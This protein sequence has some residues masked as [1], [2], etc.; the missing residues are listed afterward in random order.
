MRKISTVKRRM[1]LLCLVPTVLFCFPQPTYA[2]A[3]T[4]Y[5]PGQATAPLFLATEN[6]SVG[7]S[8]LEL[9]YDLTAQYPE[10]GSVI[11][12]YHLT[13]FSDEPQKVQF[14]LPYAGI[15]Q[16]VY[17]DVHIELNG[18]AIP[19]RVSFETGGYPKVS[20]ELDEDVNGRRLDYSVTAPYLLDDVTE[21]SCLDPSSV[22]NVA[23]VVVDPNITVNQYSTRW[24]DV[25]VVAPASYQISE[26]GSDSPSDSPYCRVLITY[27]PKKPHF[28]WMASNTVFLP[29]G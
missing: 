3:P 22:F 1:C 13:S 25:S 28:I 29:H 4:P 7:L 19:Y 12:S 6:T 21:L 14:V 9:T 24:P 8:H 17:D 5:D 2:T 20:T 23:R 11:A 26:T 27:D 15:Y 10:R 18:T 16:T